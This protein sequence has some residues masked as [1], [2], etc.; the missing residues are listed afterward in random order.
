VPPEDDAIEA[1]LRNRPS[2]SNQGLKFERPEVMYDAT[3]PT[4]AAGVQKKN[5]AGQGDVA[6][7]RFSVLPKF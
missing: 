6:G 2:Y 3:M 5:L 7:N 1:A 4:E